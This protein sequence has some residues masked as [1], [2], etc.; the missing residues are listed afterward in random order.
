M[1]KEIGKN[2]RS[3]MNMIFLFIWLCGF[4]VSSGFF[5]YDG[6][7]YDGIQDNWQV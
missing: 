7:Q 5:P 3:E 4:S 2:K 6:I 1:Y